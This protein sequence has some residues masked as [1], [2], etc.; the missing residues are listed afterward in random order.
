[1]YKFMLSDADASCK[2]YVNLIST[3]VGQYLSRRPQVIALIKELLVARELSG[4]HMIIEQDMGRN[5][6]TTDVVVTSEHDNIYYAQPV[7]TEVFSRF[8]KNRNA[9]VSPML[10]VIVEQD[11]TGDYMV[12]NAW[13]GAYFPPFPG[14]VHETTQSK[15][16]WQNHAMVHNAQAIQ[17]KTVTKECPY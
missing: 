13:I 7:K 1:M 11:N 9:Q 16:F 8:A 2:V 3:S 10:T 17:L 12:S 4:A 5:I 14:D 6:G 15:T